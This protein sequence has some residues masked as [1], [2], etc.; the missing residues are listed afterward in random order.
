MGLQLVDE[1]RAVTSDNNSIAGWRLN[2]IL[3]I[4]N[5]KNNAAKAII[6]A[7]VCSN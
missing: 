6:F 7:T 3:Y 1:E 2:M 5:L 4:Y